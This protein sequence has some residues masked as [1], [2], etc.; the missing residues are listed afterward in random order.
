MGLTPCWTWTRCVRL[1]V[2][3]STAEF[4][5][6]LRACGVVTPREGLATSATLFLK[7]P[8]TDL[9]DEGAGEGVLCIRLAA[10]GPALA[11]GCKALT[12]QSQRLTGDAR[13]EA[14]RSLQEQLGDALASALT[15]ELG[16]VKRQA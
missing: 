12:G 15:A 5:S 14:V 11:N 16:C 10:S 8:A 3:A 1:L 13:A 9:L 4:T 7:A 6:T 2:G